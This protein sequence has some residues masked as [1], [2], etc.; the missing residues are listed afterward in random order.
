[1]D[2]TTVNRRQQ[3]FDQI[4]VVLRAVDERMPVA[5]WRRH[6]QVR[7]NLGFG[8]IWR[9]RGVNGHCGEDYLSL[10]ITND[11]RHDLGG[12]CH[13]RIIYKMTV[14]CD[15]PSRVTTAALNASRTCRTRRKGTDGKPWKERVQER[16]KD[17]PPDISYSSD[18]TTLSDPLLVYH[19][20]GYTNLSCVLVSVAIS[21]CGGRTRQS[22]SDTRITG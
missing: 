3:E 15:N 16:N 22:T 8:Q 20:V 2:K 5:G 19:V 6:R 4:W 1:L 13:S 10:E 21:D 18:H 11:V 14:D 9:P 17:S 12:Q 7:A